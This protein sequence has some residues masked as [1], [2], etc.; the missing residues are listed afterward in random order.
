ME[1]VYG[2]TRPG[3]QR[4]VELTA[5]NGQEVAD[6]LKDLWRSGS[7]TGSYPAEWAADWDD[8]A[9]KLRVVF[10]Y[11]QTLELIPGDHILWTLSLSMSWSRGWPN[12]LQ[13]VPGP[14]L[15]Y[16]LTPGAE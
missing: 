16:N 6:G 2:T 4:Y 3:A 5:T 7:A 12:H 15:Y 10:R 14:D 8:Q 11:G 1:F 13:K 9:K